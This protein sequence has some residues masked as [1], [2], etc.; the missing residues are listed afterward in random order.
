M[1]THN[2]KNERIKR[3]YLSFLREAK[4]QS[5]ASLDSVAAALARFEAYT[6][7]RDFKAFHHEQAIAFKRH[8][9]EQDTRAGDGKLSKAT[10]H[11]TLSRLKRFFQWLAGQPGYKSSLSYSDSEYFNL[12][13]KDNRIATARRSRP[14]PTLEQ[15]KH[16]ISTMPTS[17][18]IEKR[19]RAV[20][21]FALLTGAR[22]GAIA[23]L[24]IK[25]VDLVAGCVHQDA[26]EVKTKF[27]KTFTTFLFPV[28]AD[29][30]RI[31]ADWIIFL[32]EERLW[33]N[34][35]P[36]F[37]RTK[38]VLDD[39]NGFAASGLDR[40]HWS[41]AAPIRKV[42]REA[43]TAAGLPYFNPHSFRKTLVALGEKLCQSPEAFKAWSQN[44]G[45]EA[46]LTTFTSYGAVA[47]PRQGEIIKSLGE[48]A[49]TAPLSESTAREL[50]A[51]LRRA[52]QASAATNA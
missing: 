8:L 43:F 29:I 25:H 41:T 50:L 34:D 16:V 38:V 19:N 14:A 24:K 31:L 3:Q 45:H 5:E 21:A 18:D 28:G 10:Q 39:R 20:I 4:R 35:D 6:R 33:G 11:A 42:F 47:M 17:S 51:H 40:G 36:L 22:D 2:S 7:Q 48:A 30:R 23:S 12:S 32:R 27:S 37:P 1:T 52:E 46:V 9:A 44:L 26:R 13:D 15:V 49:T